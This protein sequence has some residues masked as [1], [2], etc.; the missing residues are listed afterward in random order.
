VRVKDNHAHWLN[1]QA[2]AVNF[3]WNYINELSSRSIK[4]RGVILSE[5][6][7]HS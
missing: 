4:E 3:V 2:K 5:F 7:L 1:K 6:D